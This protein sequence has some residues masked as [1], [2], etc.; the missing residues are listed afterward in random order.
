MIKFQPAL[1]TGALWVV[2]LASAA[3]A[4]PAGYAGNDACKLCHSEIWKGFYKNPHFKSIASGK[5]PPDRTGCEGCHGGGEAHI[6]EGGGRKTIPNAFSLLTPK[7]AAG[8]CLSCHG[9][10]LERVNFRRSEHNL[11]GVACTRCHS[12]HHPEKPK[13]LLAKAQTELCYQCHPSARADFSLPVRHRVNEGTVQCTDCHNP[14]GSFAATWKM[15]LRPAMVRQ[16]FDSEQPC[17]N[18][19]TDKRGP[20]VYEH[21]PVRTEGCTSC[22]FAHGSA[23]ASLLRRPVV[24]TLC[25][26]CHN[27]APGFSTR[28]RGVALEDN[29]HNMLDPRYEKCTSCHVHVHGSNSDQTFFR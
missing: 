19:H 13:Y 4:V 6:N 27:G 20:F 10:D 28:G 25:L 24:F 11:A 7:Q 3:A 15:A 12:I 5:E 23:N 9:R 22:H 16:A 8:V 14:H 18:C 21:L 1:A 17:L 29:S 26:E 2:C